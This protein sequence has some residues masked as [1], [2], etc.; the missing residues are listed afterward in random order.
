MSEKDQCPMLNIEEAMEGCLSALADIDTH[1]VNLLNHPKAW[2][3]IESLVD[4]LVQSERA[5]GMFWLEQAVRNIKD[6]AI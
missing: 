1:D 5:R 4:K 3:A 6:G 2:V